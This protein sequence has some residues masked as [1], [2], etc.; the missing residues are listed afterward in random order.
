MLEIQYIINAELTDSVGS[1]INGKIYFPGGR[2]TCTRKINQLNLK[3]PRPQ[4][5]IIF[6]GVFQF[7]ACTANGKEVIGWK[8]GT[9][10]VK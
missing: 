7:F 4:R 10:V 2:C 8:E 6:D 5:Y 3:N 1:Q 9:D